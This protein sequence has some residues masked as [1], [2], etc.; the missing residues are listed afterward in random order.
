MCTAHPLTTGRQ[1]KGSKEGHK[2]RSSLNRS[3]DGGEKG[4]RRRNRVPAD[5]RSEDNH[6]DEQTLR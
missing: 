3:Q 5:R 2:E 4:K 6:G 1:E